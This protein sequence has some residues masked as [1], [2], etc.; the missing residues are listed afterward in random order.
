[1]AHGVHIAQGGPDRARVSHIAPNE[2]GVRQFRFDGMGGGQQGVQ[3]HRLVP[4]GRQCG[5]DVR[6]DEPGSSCDEYAHGAHATESGPAPVVPAPGREASVVTRPETVD[7][8]G[9]P[10]GVGRA[11][12]RAPGGHRRAMGEWGREDRPEGGAP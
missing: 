10:V 1:M 3:H 6:A 11:P 4:L 8:Q 2:L 7:G 5:D 9:P 12:P